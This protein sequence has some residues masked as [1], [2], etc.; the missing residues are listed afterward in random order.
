MTPPGSF[1]IFR[2]KTIL[3]AGFGYFRNF[4]EP[5]DFLKEPSKTGGSRQV[6]DFFQ[7]HLRTMVIYQNLVLDFL[8]TMVMYQNLVL[9]FLRTMVV[10]QDSVF[11]FFENQGYIK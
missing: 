11:D 1:E 7:K 5:P 3:L 10:Y 6:F 9:D 4:K 2:I 8:R